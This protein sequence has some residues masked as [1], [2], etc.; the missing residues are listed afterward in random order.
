MLLNISKVVNL[1][2]FSGPSCEMLLYESLMR[3]DNFT[4]HLVKFLYL[5]TSWIKE[6]RYYLVSRWS[7]FG[8][9]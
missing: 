3:I 4:C 1:A 9:Y 5:Q 2:N 7:S 6:I 8:N